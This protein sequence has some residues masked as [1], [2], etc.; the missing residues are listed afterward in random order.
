MFLS[1]EGSNGPQS[2]PLLP[3]YSLY[4]YQILDDLLANKITR[5]EVA[6]RIR[7]NTSTEQSQI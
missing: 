7:S 3:L 5:D 4:G 6:K 1:K 2:L